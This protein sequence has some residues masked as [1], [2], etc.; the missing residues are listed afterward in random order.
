LINQFRG[1]GGGKRKGERGNKYTFIRGVER[2][3]GKGE[4][5]WGLKCQK[6]KKGRARGISQ[7][8]KA[9]SQEGGSGGRR[10]HGGV[11]KKEGGRM[12]FYFE[13]AG[14]GLGRKKKKKKKKVPRLGAMKE[15]GTIYRPGGRKGGRKREGQRRDCIGM[16]EGKKGGGK[17]KKK[18]KKEYR[19]E[20]STL[21][22]KQ[23]D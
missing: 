7:R 5:S 1:R 15:R 17:K 10:G 11:L 18:R 13:D 3:E 14:G 21:I 16:E 9:E 8:G 2:G 20:A 22:M 23:R 6:G 19:A 4:M 12:D